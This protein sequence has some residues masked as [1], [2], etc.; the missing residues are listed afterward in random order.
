[1]HLKRRVIFYWNEKPGSQFFS[2]F[3]FL[4]TINPQLSE[5]IQFN[6][7]IKKV[8]RNEWRELFCQKTKG[9]K[10]KQKVKLRKTLHEW[11]FRESHKSPSQ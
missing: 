11:I 2:F 3:F 1:M 10:A 4:F 6:W 8:N 5:E 7:K 9:S